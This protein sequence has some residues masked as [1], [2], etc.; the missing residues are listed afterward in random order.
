VVHGCPVSRL[1]RQGNP[2][3]ASGSA[4]GLL[5]ICSDAACIKKKPVGNEPNRLTRGEIVMVVH[6]N[7]LPKILVKIGVKVKITV[8]RK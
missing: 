4:A 7:L 5:T 2:C 6:R 1:A 3:V 8:I